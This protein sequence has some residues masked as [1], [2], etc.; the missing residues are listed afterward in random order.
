M[1]PSKLGTCGVELVHVFNSMTI[2]L[3]SRD[4]SCKPI[5]SAMWFCPITDPRLRGLRSTDRTDPT[6]DKPLVL[7]MHMA[8]L[9]SLFYKPDPLAAKLNPQG[10]PGPRS[11]PCY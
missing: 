6:S 2:Y 11:G 8:E 1:F 7:A 4:V 5:R 9:S 10:L 3:N